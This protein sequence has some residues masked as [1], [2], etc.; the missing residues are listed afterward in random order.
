MA[1]TTPPTDLIGLREAAELLNLTVSAIRRAIAVRELRAYRV[2][3]KL[4]K[5]SR[6]DA[7]AM[8]QPYEPPTGGA[9]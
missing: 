3:P 4:L 5:V 9:A 8:I 2:G 1:T 7:L 6:A